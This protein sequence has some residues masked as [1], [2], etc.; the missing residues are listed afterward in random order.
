MSQ[1]CSGTSPII[2]APHAL[3][4]RQTC[5]LK[6]YCAARVPGLGRKRTGNMQPSRACMLDDDVS[7]RRPWRKRSGRI[8][9]TRLWVWVRRRMNTVGGGEG[10]ERPC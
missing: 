2:L 10:R 4:S 1:R 3:M 6:Q 9:K 7:R 8:D 5:A